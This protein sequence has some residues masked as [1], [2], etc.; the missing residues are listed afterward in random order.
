MLNPNKRLRQFRETARRSRTSDAEAE[1]P[2]EAPAGEAL[3]AQAEL[4]LPSFS[5]AA[6]RALRYAAEMVG[7]DADNPARLRTAALLGALRASA[8]SGMGPTTGDVVRLVLDRQTGRDALQTLAA[9]A[10]AAGLQPVEDPEP[11]AMT[12]ETLLGS[13]VRQLVEDAI[14]IHGRV[15]ADGVHLHH[16]LASG[17]DPAVSAEALAELRITLSEL[18]EHWRAS[19]AGRWPDELG[20]AWDEILAAPPAEFDLAG[21]VSRTPSTRP[22]DPARPRTDLGVREHTSTMLATV[23]ADTRTPEP[24][25][26]GLFGEWGSGKSYFMG[27]LREQVAQL[28]QVTATHTAE[29]SGRSASTPGTTRT[30]TSGRASA[31]R[32][33]SS[34][35]GR[36]A[37]RGA[38]RREARRKQ[39]E[40]LQR[41]RSSR[42]RRKRAGARRPARTGARRGER[43]APH[44]RA[45]RCPRRSPSPRS[46]R[47][48]A[49]AFHRLG[50]D[51]RASRTRLLAGEGAAGRAGGRRRPAPRPLG[52]VGRRAAR[53]L[54]LVVA[55]G[56][57]RRR[58]RRPSGDGVDRRERGVRSSRVCLAVARGCSRASA[59]HSAVVRAADAKAVRTRSRSRSA[60]SR[61]A[62]AR[63]RELQAKRDD[64]AGRSAELGRELAELSP[65][66][67]TYGFLAERAASE[68][69]RRYL[70]VISTVRKDFEQ[71][72]ER[73]KDWR[74]HPD[75]RTTREPR[76]DRIVLYIDDLDRCSLAAGGRGAPG[77]PPAARARPLRGRRRR[78]PALAPPLAAREYRGRADGRRAQEP[79][80]RWEA[81]PHDYLEKIF[82]IPFAL[83]RMSPGGFRQLSGSFAASTRPTA[84]TAPTA[85]GPA[86]VEEPSVPVEPAAVVRRRRRA[87]SCVGRRGAA[88]S[89][90]RDRRR[91]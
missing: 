26:I 30:P 86:D 84:A 63:Q 45:R 81:T 10:A 70:G 15:G 88:P 62:E 7:G 35:P 50:I 4:P 9:A 17:V 73:L 71:L 40:N 31:T 22:R 38:R 53:R 43:Q 60:G 8:V 52:G 78:R 75:T 66:E 64:A 29:E 33:S 74:E 69:Y 85:E 37:G 28:S 83:P 68:D 34:S 61:S 5:R 67:R 79:S 90:G 6:L 54:L 89:G 51:D 58:R 24:L 49:T 41:R 21:G 59:P 14:A 42:R 2:G 27:L 56:C 44:E 20:A 23:I 65:G 1:V 13:T 18:R 55:G 72:I 77:R 32:S 82:N 25:S 47:K 87:G 11:E 16:V 80:E 19:I 39:L 76:I 46:A 36:R 57:S 12:G 3:E 48:V 91:A